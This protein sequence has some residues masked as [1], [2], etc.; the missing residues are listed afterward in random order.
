MTISKTKIGKRITRKTNPE[1]VRTLLVL[2]KNKSWLKIAQIISSSTRK[3]SSINLDKI[4]KASKEGDTI[5]VPGKVL[6]SGRLDKKIRIAALSFSEK[7]MEK[8]REVKAEIASL[9][10]EVKKNPEARGIKILR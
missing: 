5:V 3:F 8:L 10:E 4:N 7:A 1:I 6:S 2:K 9:I